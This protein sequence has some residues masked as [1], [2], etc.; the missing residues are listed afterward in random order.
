MQQL[1]PVVNGEVE[2]HAGVPARKLHEQAGEEIIAGA[3]DADVERP[4]RHSFELLHRLVRLAKLLND[5]A[6]VVEH[7]GPGVRQ[8]DLP[9]ELLE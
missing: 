1:G 5:R 7:L 8:I 6:A 4:A 9:A 2:L 3:D